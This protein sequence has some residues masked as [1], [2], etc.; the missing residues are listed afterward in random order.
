[1]HV[2]EFHAI[3][4][5]HTSSA[6]NSIVFALLEEPIQ[7][8]FT[9]SYSTAR[10]YYDRQTCDQWKS[11]S[12]KYL[13]GFKTKSALLAKF[14]EP[15]T[16]PPVIGATPVGRDQFGVF[17]RLPLSAHLDG[18][19]RWASDAASTEP[20]GCRWTIWLGTRLRHR[21]DLMVVTETAGSLRVAVSCPEG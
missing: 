15:Q 13:H 3:R 18:P 14:P 7:P 4:I 16:S 9:S 5:A 10:Y 11:L 17:N 21:L 6:L 1:M 8:L 20:R 19:T 2:V 12:K